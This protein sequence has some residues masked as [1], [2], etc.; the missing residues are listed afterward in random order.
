[1]K[2]KKSLIY[3]LIICLVVSTFSTTTLAENEDYF[4]TLRIFAYNPSSPNLDYAMLI[5]QQLREINIDSEVI[6]PEGWPFWLDNLMFRTDWDLAVVSAGEI[7]SPDMRN[8]YTE[9]GNR[10]IFRLNSDIP[11][12]N[13]SKNLQDLA[14][15]TSDLE[16]RQYYQFEWQNMFMDKV[17]A[18]LPT[19]SP[20]EYEAVWANIEGFEARWGIADSLPYMEY[21][22]YHDGQ[23]SLDEFNIADT[24]WR[25]LSPIKDLTQAEKFLVDLIF[26]PII[27]K[28][29]DLSSLKTGIVKDWEKI[30]DNHFVFEMNNDIWW[31]PSY[32]I[33]QR[34]DTSIPLDFISNEDLLAG[35]QGKYSNGTNEQ[36]MA[37]DAVFSLLA[38][39]NDNVTL[40]ADHYDWLSKCYVDP[41]DNLKFHVEVDAN[42]DTPTKENYM[43]FWTKLFIPILPEF[44][45]NSTNTTISQTRGG[46]EYIGLYPG[47]TETTEWQLFQTSPFGCGKY[48]LDY[49]IYNNTT[50]LRESPYWFGKGAIDGSHQDLDISTINIRVIYDIYT[51]LAEY[52]AGKLDWVSLTPFPAERKDMQA[53]VRHEVQTYITYAFNFIAFNLNRSI[54]GGM[55]NQIW[56]NIPGKE[57][58]TKALA[59]R[60]AI[61][62]AIDRDEINQEIHDGEYMIMHSPNP[63]IIDYYYGTEF[64]KY[65]H[66]LELAWEWLE[67]AG[68]PNLFPT[69]TPTPSQT[70]TSTIP[71]TMTIKLELLYSLF[72]IVLVY[73][74]KFFRRKQKNIRE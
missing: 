73:A 60:K 66:N 53:N 64:F 34:N 28:N 17:L 52:K 68:Y 54:I 59:I 43:D 65:S 5:S 56:L 62:Y 69:P 10:N 49:S 22:G 33:S 18:L 32:N 24:N 63:R 7:P 39:S 70:Q 45:L 47:I 42:P 1:M 31:N 37:K 55:D 15:S 21:N 44:Y 61:C 26:E 14:A 13:E 48:M 4:F 50:V 41:F 36:V 40:F 6:F 12:Y 74:L 8:Y 30:N 20:R 29:P 19:F 25:N 67:A 27:V 3:F 9:E 2:F 71:S 72:G 16:L 46:Q 35:L 23:V 38:Y 11:Y 51:E 58:Y 57:E